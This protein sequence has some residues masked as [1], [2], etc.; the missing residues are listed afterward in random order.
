M[1]TV[2]QINRP[3]VHG[4]V[5]VSWIGEVLSRLHVCSDALAVNA[6]PVIIEGVLVRGRFDEWRAESFKVQRL[7]SKARTHT[8]CWRTSRR[9]QER[10]REVILSVVST[11]AGGR[12]Q[13]IQPSSH[14]PE[15]GGE[16]A[17]LIELLGALTCS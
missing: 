14:A 15:T 10:A 13:Q 9:N 7:V 5:Q 12:P 1:K 4:S 17:L 8:A 11:W 2:L 16:G 3:Y 6:V